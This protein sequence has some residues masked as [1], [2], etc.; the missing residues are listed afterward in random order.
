MG[1]YI[2]P[3]DMTKEQFLEKF[4]IECRGDELEILED[5]LPVVLVDSGYFTAAAI[6]YSRYELSCLVDPFDPRPRKYYMVPREHLKP[7]MPNEAELADCRLRE[8]SK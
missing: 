5:M 6:A 1:I 4:G 7:Y 2:N 3:P 8:E